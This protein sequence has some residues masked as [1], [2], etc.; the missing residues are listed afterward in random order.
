MFV[1]RIV[2]FILTLGFR[3]S[4]PANNLPVR[5]WRYPNCERQPVAVDQLHLP[6][7][8]LKIFPNH[9]ATK[10]CHFFQVALFLN[11]RRRSQEDGFVCRKLDLVQVWAL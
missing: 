1:Y 6:F 3:F 7:R 10:I 2:L 9:K 4:I 11:H 5:F 8:I